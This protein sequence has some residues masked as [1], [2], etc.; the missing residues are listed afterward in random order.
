MGTDFQTKMLSVSGVS[1][2]Q[3]EVEYHRVLATVEASDAIA[4]GNL[5]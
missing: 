2:L 3:Y 5:A 4:S 1:S